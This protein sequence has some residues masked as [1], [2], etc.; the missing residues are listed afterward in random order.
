MPLHYAPGA[1]PEGATPKVR[2][3][4]V[5]RAAKVSE[6]EEREEETEEPEEETEE[7]TM[8]A[9]P[10]EEPQETPG[11]LSQR[12]PGDTPEKLALGPAPLDLEAAIRR[13]AA[14]LA[15]R[16]LTLAVESIEARLAESM[17]LGPA[18]KG[19]GDLYSTKPP[20]TNGK[21]S[22]LV[23][24]LLPQQQ[25]ILQSDF[26]QTV[27]FSFWKN[28]AIALLKQKAEHVDRILVAADFVSHASTEALNRHRS[29]TTLVRGGMGAMRD[30]LAHIVTG[31]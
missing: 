29:K 25:A 9:V 15:E 21:P 2:H 30:E 6:Q 5:T 8:E 10:D 18:S 17:P 7:P 3:A 14:L 4:P 28:G 16:I 1:L 12:I 11:V 31:G 24:G 22:V 19:L 27:K 13:S 23:V 26:H 20:E